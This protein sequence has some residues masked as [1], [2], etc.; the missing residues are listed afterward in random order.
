MNTI[1][2]KL[3][4]PFPD[5]E[6]KWRV[7]SVSIPKNKVQLLAYVDARAVQDRLDE[8][9]GIEGW[10]SHFQCIEKN[11]ICTITCHFPDLNRPGETISIS[12]SDGA[13]QTD[14]EAWKGGISDAFKRAAVQFGVG[15]YLYASDA[16]W[17]EVTP[18][19]PQGVPY[20]AYN[21]VNYSKK[22]ETIKGYYK[23]P[24]LAIT[25][26]RPSPADTCPQTTISSSALNHQRPQLPAD[27]G[28]V[29]SSLSPEKIKLE[30]DGLICSKAP[31]IDRPLIDLTLDEVR[32]YF[33]AIKDDDLILDQ[34]KQIVKA[35]G[36]I[37][38]AELKK[39]SKNKQK[40]N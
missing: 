23:V 3:K 1:E 5:K 33:K 21:Y 38:N 35:R 26:Q 19:R 2:Q 11:F 18:Q 7:G 22:G 10:E 16:P 27:V 12:K 37:L 34:E 36:V 24:S 13:E 4:A 9:F 17:V 8:V 39:N 15:R 20:S 30:I 31:F 28:G 29:R 6:V 14:F 25:D 40:N 32:E